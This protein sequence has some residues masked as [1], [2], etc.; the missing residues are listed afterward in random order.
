[1]L[2]S[3][4]AAADFEH[5]IRCHAVKLVPSMPCS[6][7]E[8]G[9]A[10]GEV[11]GYETVKLAAR[12]SG[13]IVLFLDNTA[14]VGEVVIQD[15]FTPVLPRVNPAT[16]VTI[17]NAPPFIKNKSLVK[18]LSRFGQSLTNKNGVAWL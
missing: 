8:A 11:V 9:L 13:A 6:M 2:V 3:G 14:K 15:T 12:M 10:V 16:K 4:A 1:M 17:S 7:E 18:E 5:L